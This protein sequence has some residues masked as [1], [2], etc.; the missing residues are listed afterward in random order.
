MEERENEQKDSAMTTSDTKHRIVTIASE[1]FYRHGYEK[2]T[3][4]M[5]AQEVG[6][7]HVSILSHFRNK[8]EL[9]AE[10]VYKYISALAR[11]CLELTDRLPALYLEDGYHFQMLWWSLHFKL[12]TENPDFRRFFVS[13]Y[14]NGPVVLL[15]SPPKQPF[16]EIFPRLNFVPLKDE[17][18]TNSL[19]VAL[20]VNLCSLID[21][22]VIDAATAADL[23]IRLSATI[24]FIPEY[25]SDAAEIRQFIVEYLTDYK[26]DMLQD[27]LLV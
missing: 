10:T 11:I 17:F 22:N 21:M 13:Y 14:R 6:I 23:I 15:D 24:G 3:L 1:M 4:R 9:A 5:I 18:V 12:M 27:M 19:L 7:T 20:D 8:S 16:Q 2:T 26:I 25:Q